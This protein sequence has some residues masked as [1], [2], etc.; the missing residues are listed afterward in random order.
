RRL[1]FDSGAVHL[2][3][4]LVFN[5]LQMYSMIYHHQ[6]VRA[7]ECLVK[8]IFELISDVPENAAGLKLSSPTDFLRA[9]DS[10][11][12]KLQERAKGKLRKV[13]QDFANRRLFKRALVISYATV[14]KKSQTSLTALA[15]ESLDRLRKLR[16]EIATKA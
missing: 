8:S 10:I 14:S 15:T 7:T 5:K 11:F 1:A 12:P 9:D 3:E 4:Q 2:L 6:K 16:G 13:L